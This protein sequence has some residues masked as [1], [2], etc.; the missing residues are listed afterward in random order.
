MRL[1][2][3]WRAPPVPL[4]CHRLPA[5][6]VWCV[7]LK[8]YINK[9]EEAEYVAVYLRRRALRVSP[10]MRPAAGCIAAGRIAA[11]ASASMLTITATVIATRAQGTP[12]AS[13][14][15]FEDRRDRTT[16]GFSIRLCGAPGAP[17][18][19]SVC[20]RSVMGKAFGCDSE[21]SW[22]WEAFLSG[23]N[24]TERPWSTGDKLRFILNLD[25][26]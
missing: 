10:S 13:A 24:L 15:N 23:A 25:M 16:L 1:V 8:R 17:T 7:D 4:A 6:S 2:R 14:E 21:T 20:G 22:G 19:N 5:G 9:A 11:V 18:S 3:H 26:L 12:F